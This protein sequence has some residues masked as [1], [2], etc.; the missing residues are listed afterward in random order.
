[1]TISITARATATAAPSHLRTRSMLMVSSTLSSMS[2]NAVYREAALYLAHS[3]AVEIAVHRHAVGIYHVIVQ[4]HVVHAADYLQLLGEVVV[5]DR[6]SGA[7][8]GVVVRGQY[9]VGMT[10]RDQPYDLLR[11]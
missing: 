2:Q 6:R 5:H 4:P 3:A 11:R 1:I 7:A 9:A 8:V 10:H